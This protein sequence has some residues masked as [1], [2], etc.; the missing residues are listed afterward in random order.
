MGEPAP[1][2][3]KK[4]SAGKGKMSAVEQS[5]KGKTNKNWNENDVTIKDAIRGL[6][7]K[8]FG[9]EKKEGKHEEQKKPTK[10]DIKQNQE[11]QKK[12]VKAL[13]EQHAKLVVK[14]SAEDKKGKYNDDDVTIKGFIKNVLSSIFKGENGN[15]NGNSGKEQVKE[16]VPTKDTKKVKKAPEVDHEKLKIYL[17]QQEEA[18]KL[19]E[20]KNKAT[21][22]TKVDTPAKIKNT[23]DDS[24]KKSSKSKPAPSK[25]K[26]QSA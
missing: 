25:T 10:K 20:S 13:Q 24:K 6:L 16:N 14:N 4:Q 15:G 11:N 12:L 19:A 9:G 2:K 21:K 1:S 23:K 17:S 7:S 3:T 8:L 18:R 26:K 5:N 22:K